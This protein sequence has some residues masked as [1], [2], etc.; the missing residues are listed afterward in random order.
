[1]TDHGCSEKHVIDW[2]NV[3]VKNL[4]SVKMVDS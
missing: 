1:M 4:A 3:N 2:D